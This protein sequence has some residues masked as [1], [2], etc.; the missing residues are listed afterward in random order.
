[1]LKNINHRIQL[2]FSLIEVVVSFAILAGLGVSLIQSQMNTSRVLYNAQSRD[3]A[4]EI[5]HA[6]LQEIERNPDLAQS[7]L[8]NQKFNEDHP[9]YPG[10]W[11]I[12][13]TTTKSV[14]SLAQMQKV[15][16][17]IDWKQNGND[18][19]VSDFILLDVAT[20]LNDVIDNIQNF[21]D[22]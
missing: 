13:L 1:M 14:F 21:N 6:K 18:R 9:L 4:W 11:S 20:S 22:E 19:V 2:G 7:S 15:T 3:M 17:K 10:H 12:I 5:I 8:K 16:Y